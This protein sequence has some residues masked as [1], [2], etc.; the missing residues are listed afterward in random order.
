MDLPLFHFHSRPRGPPGL[1]ALI[2]HVHGQGPTEWFLICSRGR[3]NLHV[4]QD[5]IILAGRQRC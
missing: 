5:R 3:A 4:G 2:V 1:R